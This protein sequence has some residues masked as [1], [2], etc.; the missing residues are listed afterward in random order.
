MPT[1]LLSESED[2]DTEKVVVSEKKVL[3]SFNPVYFY[4]MLEWTF[5]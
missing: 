2:F 1:R 3:W 4:A 5:V